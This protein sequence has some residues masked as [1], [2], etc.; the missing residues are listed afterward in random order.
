MV[1]D[2]E[3]MIRDLTEK[4][5]WNGLTEQEKLQELEEDEEE[6]KEEEKDT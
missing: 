3:T 2:K 4:E 6:K 5:R 1:H